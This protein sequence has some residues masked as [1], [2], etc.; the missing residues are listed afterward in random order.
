[1][2]VLFSRARN[3]GFRLCP[4]IRRSVCDDVRMKNLLPLLTLAALVS[5]Q[6]N[7]SHPGDAA[8]TEVKAVDGE[9]AE[10]QPVAVIDVTKPDTMIGQPLEKAQAACEAAEVPHRVV[11]VDGEPRPVTMDYRLERLNFKVDGGMVTR[12]TK[13]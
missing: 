12:V 6:T 11:E 5:C 13:G 10:A 9:P 3:G 7:E 4:C 1:M 2:F 8:P